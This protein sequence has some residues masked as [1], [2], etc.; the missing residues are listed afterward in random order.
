MALQAIAAHRTQHIL[1]CS[2]QIKT[3]HRLFLVASDLMQYN[4]EYFFIFFFNSRQTWLK[5]GLNL[6][7]NLKR[8]TSARKCESENL[9]SKK[10]FYPSCVFAQVD[11]TCKASG[12]MGEV[13]HGAFQ[14]SSR[15]YTGD[16]FHPSVAELHIKK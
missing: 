14:F 1:Y 5:L 2:Q 16:A 11:C 6:R 12:L 4:Q 8:K 15:I 9:C 10:P 3:A 13:A 7:M